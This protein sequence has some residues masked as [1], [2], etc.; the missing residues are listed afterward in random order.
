MRHNAIDDSLR[1]VYMNVTYCLPG[2]Q[3][4]QY[5]GPIAFLVSV[6]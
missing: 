3:Y 2:F 5:I 6:N 4:R 1:L